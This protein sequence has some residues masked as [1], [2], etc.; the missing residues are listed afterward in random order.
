MMSNLMLITLVLLL[1]LS[2]PSA[3]I[4]ARNSPLNAAPPTTRPAR[5]K[6]HGFATLRPRW[7]KKRHT[8][9]GREIGDCLPKGFRPPPSAPSRYAN[10]QPLG[11]SVYCSSKPQ[12]KP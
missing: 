6:P 10:Y 11:S 7:S 12:A 8:F 1:F 2:T 5:P 4:A 3:T 9:R